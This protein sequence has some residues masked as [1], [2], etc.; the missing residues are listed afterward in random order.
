MEVQWPLV[1]TSGHI[2]SRPPLVLSHLHMTQLPLGES[3]VVDTSTVLAGRNCARYLGDFGGAV[4]TAERV[5]TGYSLGNTA[6]PHHGH[7][8]RVRWTTVHAHKETNPTA[9]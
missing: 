5:D 3:R 1:G 7:C 8:T 2:A 6:W 9:S 4:I